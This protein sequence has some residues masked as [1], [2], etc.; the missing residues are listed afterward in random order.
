M[1][2][3]ILTP[4]EENKYNIIKELV[5]HS[6]NKRRAALKLNCSDWTRYLYSWYNDRKLVIRIWCLVPKRIEQTTSIKAKNALKEQIESIEDDTPHSRRS[7]S[8]YMGEMIQMDASNY[9]WYGIY[10]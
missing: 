1:K 4:M 3:I 7:R 6:G 5:D 8:K 2:K 10:T 9:E